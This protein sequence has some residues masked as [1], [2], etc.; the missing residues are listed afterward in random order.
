MRSR[1]AGRLIIAA[2]DSAIQEDPDQRVARLTTLLQELQ[3]HTD[4]LYALATEAGARVG[5][6]AARS[7]ATVLRADARGR[8]RR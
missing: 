4:R 8:R 6:A 1:V 7:G 5:E 2:E 3:E